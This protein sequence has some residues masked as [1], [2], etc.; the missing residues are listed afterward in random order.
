MKTVE[1]AAILT[2]LVA[3][4]GWVGKKVLKENLTG[5]PASSVMNYVK[6]AG[7]VAGSM[8]LKDYL[9]KEKIIPR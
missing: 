8:V 9:E 1:D 2:S 6:M 4:V 7:V 5:D 3:G